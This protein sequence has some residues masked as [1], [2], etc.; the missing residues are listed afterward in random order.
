MDIK[1]TSYNLNTLS[2]I[3]K[4][5]GVSKQSVPRD[6]FIKSKT[7]P[8]LSKFSN[9][10][11]KEATGLLFSKKEAADLTDP[12]CLKA[13]GLSAWSATV[14][15]ETGTYFAGLSEK[16]DNGKKFLAAFNPDGSMRWKIDQDSPVYDLTPDKKGGVIVRKWTKIFSYDKDGNKSWE[17]SLPDTQDTFSEKPVIGPDNTVYYSTRKNESEPYK[18]DMSIVAVKDGKLKWVYDGGNQQNNNVDMI[19]TKKG[20]IL[21]TV[22]EERKPKSLMRRMTHG[23]EKKNFLVCLNPDGSKKFEIEVGVKGYKSV[24]PIEGSD[25]NIIYVDKNDNAINS[26]T[27]DGELKWSCPVEGIGR[28]PAVDDQGN[29]YVPT[30]DIFLMHTPPNS[31]LVCIDGKSGEKKWD[32]KIANRAVKDSPLIKDNEIYL[33]ITREY[34]KNENDGYLKLN[35]KGAKLDL[36]N[37]TSSDGNGFVYLPN[38]ELI[39]SSGNNHHLQSFGSLEKIPE[40]SITKQS[41]NVNEEEGKIELKEKTVVI[42]GVELKKGK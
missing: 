25:G 7:D 26:I 34:G 28:P 4:K 15:P 22:Q 35:Q 37:E 6:A 3:G 20:N 32:Y 21:F 16:G 39:V 17:F 5:P 19:V 9:L 38:N 13:D 24:R 31:A 18:T 42:G 29:I 30:G 23:N 1:K 12:F 14:D 41:G 33:P 2:N 27:P 40:E 11:T 36:I 10:S 8:S